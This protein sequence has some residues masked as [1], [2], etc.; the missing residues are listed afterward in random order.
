LLNND[1]VY[2]KLRSWLNPI[3]ISNGELEIC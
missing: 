3:S 2:D 1:V